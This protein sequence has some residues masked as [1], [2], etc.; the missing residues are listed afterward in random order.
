MCDCEWR[1]ISTAPKDGTTI[2]VFKFTPPAWSVIGLAFWFGQGAISGWM[3]YGLPVLDGEPQTLGLA[4]PTHWMPLPAP[5][6]SPAQ[7]EPK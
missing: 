1:P 4:H 7:G 6:V 3:S 2:M 5:P